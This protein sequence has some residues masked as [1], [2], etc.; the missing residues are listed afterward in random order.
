VTGVVVVA[1]TAIAVDAATVVVLLA[2]LGAAW[3]VGAGQT[4][5]IKQVVATAHVR[6]DRRAW[7]VPSRLTKR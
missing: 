2:A 3:L 7:P 6:I 1:V 5:T 4:A